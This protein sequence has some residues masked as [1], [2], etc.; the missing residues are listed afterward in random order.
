MYLSKKDQSI[1]GDILKIFYKEYNENSIQIYKDTVELGLENNKIIEAESQSNEKLLLNF[2]NFYDIV[3]EKSAVPKAE[4][5]Y[6]SD[7]INKKIKSMD[8]DFI[9][10]NKTFERYFKDGII[11]NISSIF[12]KKDF[13]LLESDSDIV[14][15]KNDVLF[16]A[17]REL[18]RNYMMIRSNR[19]LAGELHLLVKSIINLE[20]IQNDTIIPRQITQKVG[21][22]QLGLSLNRIS[23]IDISRGF[24]DL[25]EKDKRLI[26]SLSKCAGRSS[27]LIEMAKLSEIRWR[28]ENISRIR[29]FEKI[30]KK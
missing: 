10:K 14:L 24:I 2:L 15:L 4:Y 8:E 26:K 18:I 25:N 17:D 29:E 21:V 20:G 28:H 13:K 30:K 1:L 7:A 22:I 16:S 11:S 3:T 19:L 27:K 23:K 12:Q 9:I 6:V 5:I